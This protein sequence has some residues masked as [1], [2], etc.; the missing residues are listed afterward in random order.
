MHLGLIK[1]MKIACRW[2]ASRLANINQLVWMKYPVWDGIIE[3]N[4]QNT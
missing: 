1:G 2:T 4:A 3:K